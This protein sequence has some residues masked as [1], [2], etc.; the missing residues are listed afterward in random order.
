MVNIISR[1]LLD[2]LGPVNVAFITGK[3]F[4]W[5]SDF[6]SDALLTMHLYT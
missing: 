6:L 4:E 5:T 1:F 3:Q 2:I